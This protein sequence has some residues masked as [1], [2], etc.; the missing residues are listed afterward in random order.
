M[1]RC[2]SAHVLR[3]LAAVAVTWFHFTNGQPLFINPDSLLAWSGRYGYL[4]VPVFFVISGFV[5]PYS[6]DRMGYR[7]PNDVLTFAG[8]RFWRI[9]PAYIASIVLTVVVLLASAMLPG[10]KAAVPVLDNPTIIGHLT[11]TVPWVGADWLVP[12]YWS[13]AIEIQFYIAMILL[14]PALLSRKRGILFAMLFLLGCLCFVSSDRTLLFWYLPSFCA[15][16]CWYLLF[17]GRLSALDAYSQAAGFVI[18]AGLT[19]PIGY[20]IATAATTAALAMPIRASWRLFAFLGTTSY[21]L[22]LVH[23]A[24]GGRIVNLGTRL[25]NSLLIQSS[26][27]ALSMLASLVAAYVFWKIFEGG[28]T[29]EASQNSKAAGPGFL[30]TARGQPPCR[31][32]LDDEPASPDLRG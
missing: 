28:G 24:I 15:G 31:K 20:A 1:P 4:G 3:G 7:F 32:P 12:I 18:I 26:I 25:P 2:E 14:G 19:M 22:Y 9:Y 5:I 17:S 16:I 10:S 8:K 13:L 11:Y 27:L 23:S 30:E 29:T 6:L 21:S